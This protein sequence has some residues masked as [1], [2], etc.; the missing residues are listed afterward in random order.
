MADKS[1]IE[2]TDATWNIVTGCSIVSPGCTNCYAMRLA[3]T[4]LKH[5]T[6]RRG[7]T[8]EVNGKH[9]WT[10]DV[11]V[12]WEWIDQPLQWSRARKIF[13]AANGDLFH[14]GIEPSNIATI[15]GIMIAAHHLRGHVFQILTK[16]PDLMRAQFN[17]PEFWEAAN[18]QAETEI[19]ERCDALAR[20][21]DDARATCAEYGPD[22]PPP[23]LWLGVSIE[24]Q[25]RADARR[26]AM[27]ALAAMG[28][29]IFVSYEP[30]L[31]PVDFKGWEFV[32]QIIVGGESGRDARPMDPDWARV[33]LAF[34]RAHGIAFFFKQWGEYRP[35]LP[36]ESLDIDDFPSDV[37]FPTWNAVRRVGKARAGRLLDGKEYSE[38]PSGE[39]ATPHETR[40]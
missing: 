2:W 29:R 26:E 32:S 4:R 5:T 24:D 27:R 10:D 15:F 21:R 35:L 22:H 19:L 9:V 31:G 18:A 38:F 17:D 39:G 40:S 25:L 11:R 34:C 28:W 36:T 1:S 37:L 3:G 6:S 12:N 14:P 13:V 30:A 20:R 23:G 8:S 33:V 16:R 7:L